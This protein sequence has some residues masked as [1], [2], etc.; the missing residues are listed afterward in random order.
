MKLVSRGGRSFSLEGLTTQDFKWK[1]AEGKPGL[2][3]NFAPQRYIMVWIDPEVAAELASHGILIRE[4]DDT[5]NKLGIRPWIKFIIKPKV[6]VNFTTGKEEFQPVVV[7]ITPSVKTVLDSEKQLGN[8]DSSLIESAD[9]AFHYYA[10]TGQQYP[11][12]Y[13]DRM[14]F[15]TADSVGTGY[16]DLDAKYGIDPSDPV[17]DEPEDEVPFR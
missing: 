15:T 17:G 12:L 9:I 1:N 14:W 4:A 3:P 13:L 6:G 8:I 16:A 5:H 11:S 2:N 10:G 7:K